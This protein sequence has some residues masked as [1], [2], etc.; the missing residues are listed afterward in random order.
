MMALGPRLVGPRHIIA[1]LLLWRRLIVTRRRRL[2]VPLRRTL[3]IPLR[4]RII[5]LRPRSVILW[6]PRLIISW[7]RRVIAFR[8]G[9]VAG[10]AFRPAGFRLLAL[11]LMPRLRT[12]GLLAGRT[13]PRIVAMILRKARHCR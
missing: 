9:L 12:A 1:W 7:W 10:L 3:I 11:L 8:S 2:I 4:W 13:R 5:S 6:R